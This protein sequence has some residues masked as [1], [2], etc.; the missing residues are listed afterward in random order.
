MKVNW[1][2]SGKSVSEIYQQVKIKFAFLSSP[3]DG[4]RQCHDFIKCR[5]FLHDAVKAHLNKNSWKIYGFEYEYGVNPPICM[6]AMNMLVWTQTSG[7]KDKKEI[8]VAAFKDMMECSLKLL[9]HYEKVMKVS[10]T[11]VVDTEDKNGNPVTIFTG[12]PIWMSSPF[13]ISAYTYLI[14]MGAKKLKFKTNK[15][16]MAEYERVLGLKQGDNDTI[17][18]KDIWNKLDIVLKN[19][20]K[21]FGEEDVDPLFFDKKV[22]TGTYHNNCGIQSLCRFVSPN[23]EAHGIIKKEMEKLK[24]V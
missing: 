12:D 20:T 19:T 8:N 5:D 21:L 23:T 15:D 17:Y 11:E 2:S 18:L 4:D 7:T 9:H 6:E 22:S 10:K 24:R 1:F 3:K 14:R 16:L 13:L